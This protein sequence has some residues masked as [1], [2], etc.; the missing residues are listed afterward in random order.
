[1]LGAGSSDGVDER[2]M[3]PAGGNAAATAAGVPVAGGVSR[4]GALGGRARE[5]V[6]EAV[7]EEEEEAADCGACGGTG[8]A[9]VELCTNGLHPLS[10]AVVAVAAAAL[11]DKRRAT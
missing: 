5:F 6:L 8:E 7:A 4:R 10:T 1:V 2:V 9:V 3:R 11:A